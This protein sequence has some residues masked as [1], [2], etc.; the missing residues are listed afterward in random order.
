MTEMA[1]RHIPIDDTKC[2]VCLN[3]ALWM[4]GHS[5]YVDQSSAI[6]E[7]TWWKATCTHCRTTV[8]RHAIAR[9]EEDPSIYAVTEEVW[10]SEHGLTMRE[11]RLR[12][13]VTP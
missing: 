5:G 9:S 10:P 4:I 13:R 8:E 6:E 2:P 7:I 11:N 1:I 3:F 12:E